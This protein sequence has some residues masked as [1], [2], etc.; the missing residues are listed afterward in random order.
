M[1][2]AY[3]MLSKV[4]TISFTNEGGETYYLD[5][6]SPFNL[7]V[8]LINATINFS[9][10]DIVKTIIPNVVTLR[11]QYMNNKRSS[12]IA[13]INYNIKAKGYLWEAGDNALAQLSFNEK[14]KMFS[15]DKLP[16]LSGFEYYAGGIFET[17]SYKLQASKSISIDRFDW[18]NRHGANWVTSVK[19]QGT[20]NSC[21]A[22]AA[23][24][25]LES[26]INLYYNQHIDEDLSE[27]AFV[28]CYYG[29]YRSDVVTGWPTPPLQQC[30]GINAPTNVLCRFKELGAVDES[31]YPYTNVF[32]L[33]GLDIYNQA[34]PNS[35][36]PNSCTICGN[37]CSDYLQRLWKIDDFR[38]LDAPAYYYPAHTY[39]EILTE[40]NLEENIILNGPVAFTYQPW[41]HSMCFVGFGMVKVGYKIYLP[42]GPIIIQPED[43][44]IGQVYW[45]VKNSGGTGWGENGFVNFFINLTDIAV[46]SI[47][48]APITHPTTTSYQVNYEDADG[49]G[50]YWWGIG[51]KPAGCPGPAE[52]DCD[53]SN[54]FLGPYATDYSCS[55]N[56]N[57]FTYN[58][59]PYN[60][61]SDESWDFEKWM[62]KDVIINAGCTLTINSKVIFEHNAKIIVKQ[63]G[64]LIIDGGTLTSITACSNNLWQGVEV[65]GDKTLSQLPETN[66][67]VI[68]IINGGTI[69]NA[70]AVIRT[71]NTDATHPLDFTGGII[72]A[73]GAI[74]KNNYS[75]IYI[76]PYHNHLPNGA[77]T[78]NISYIQNCNFETNSVLNNPTLNPTSFIRLVDVEGIIIKGNTFTN[79]NPAPTA[80]NEKGDGISVYN[81]SCT[82]AGICTSGTIPCSSYQPNT[83]Q[84]L[85][86]AIQ[87]NNTNSLKTV[88]I[89]NNTFSNNYRGILLRYTNNSVITSNQFDVPDILTGNPQGSYGMY[90]ESCSGYKIEGNEF[91]TTNSG[92]YGVAFKTFTNQV[93][94]TLYHNQFNN[95][96]I[97]VLTANSFPPP[98]LLK[99]TGPSL[100][101]AII[102][103]LQIKCNRFEDITNKNIAVTSGQLG[104]SQGKCISVTSP[105]NNMFSITT[106]EHIFVNPGAGSFGYCHSTDALTTPVV[107]TSGK[108]SLL[109]CSAFPVFIETISCPSTL[110]I[111]IDQPSTMSYISGHNTQINT[112]VSVIDGSNTQ[113]LLNN[114]NSNINSGELRNILL[115]PGPYLSDTVLIAVIMKTNP[116]PSGILKEIIVPNSP[117]TTPVMNAIN[118]INLPAGIMQEIQT[119]QTGTSE[120]AVLEQQIATLQQ[121]KD[122]ATAELMRYYL[123]DTTGIKIDSVILFL[124]SQ[125]DLE[126]QKQLV[127]AYLMQENCTE[128]NAVLDSLPQQSEEEIIFKEFYSIMLELCS[129]GKT[130]F[131]LTPEQEQTMY[132]IVATNTTTATAAK[133]VLTL[134]YGEYY[135]EIIE[136]LYE[137]GEAGIKG[138]LYESFE[139]G[140]S[141]VLDTKIYLFD[142]NN[143]LVTSV[144][145]AITDST[146]FFWFNNYY[147][148]LLDTT[149]LYSI[150]TTGGFKIDNPEL[151]TIPEWFGSSPLT[152]NLSKVNME[153]YDNYDS[154]DSIWS[155]GTKID[156]SG[157]IYVAGRTRRMVSND[158]VILIKYSPQG[159]RLWETIY[160]SGINAYDNANDMTTDANGNCYLSLTSENTNV[161]LL[162]YNSNGQLLWSKSIN[163]TANTRYNAFKVKLTAS[164]NVCM[165]GYLATIPDANSDVF[166]AMFD[167]N[168]NQKWLKTFNFSDYDLLI[169]M[170]IDKNDNIVFTGAVYNSTYYVKNCIT[171]KTNKNGNLLWSRNYVTTVNSN[172]QIIVTDNMGNIYVAGIQGLGSPEMFLVSFN[173]NGS[174]QWISTLP[175][176]SPTDMMISSDNSLYIG[177]VG[178]TDIFVS[179]YNS[180]GNQ[181]WLST[182]NGISNGYDAGSAIAL[183][184][185]DEVYITGWSATSPVPVND[186]LRDMTTLKYNNNGELLWDMTFNTPTHN[187]NSG[188]DIIVSENNN[189]YVTGQSGTKAHIFMS[190]FKYSQCPSTAELR[191]GM[192]PNIDNNESDSDIQVMNFNENAITVY[193]NPYSDNTLIELV[194]NSD[195]DV[196]LEVYTMT[197][198]CVANIY[199]GLAKVGTYKYEFSAKKLGYSAGTYILKGTVNN[200]VSSYWLVE[201]K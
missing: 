120:R 95:L 76:A 114:V 46:A 189:V 98:L 35:P 190:T 4:G 130:V 27:Q 118:I 71:L 1:Y 44:R 31:C 23:T 29:I 154:P 138:N 136:E 127:T 103:G 6:N 37:L 72:K 115:A 97:G 141:P 69:E 15:A 56:C 55:V 91:A 131:D 12:N 169:D 50:Y 111:I 153:W 195:A 5:A 14:K 168:G 112:L 135:P 166:I 194:L 68:E 8:E 196:S 11:N 45:I 139:C 126:S 73:N 9:T 185:N 74:F 43:P 80:L 121:Q 16:N 57:L 140:G 192:A 52:R 105:A 36:W 100:P 193:P 182:Y 78:G 42:S 152:L 123:N 122:S 92:K 61:S 86:Y 125:T 108:V 162:K 183:D 65:Q 99:A 21:W 62:N 51:D 58:S 64:T 84:G 200:E 158:D 164:G 34:C 20:E 113:S 176:Y 117:V 24:A 89:S 110:N 144:S 18:R 172:G 96:D 177:G 88:S 59:T 199:T 180:S 150:N 19:D 137:E 87:V 54:P 81:A 104:S 201:L 143:E 48:K 174:Q 107:Y 124:E 109:P 22:F 129:Q 171:A 53:D 40:T 134:V 77:L 161:V 90:I 7:K 148:S 132:S 157:N 165:A 10:V 38:E 184:Q 163:N 85:N 159:V 106:D 70:I 49:D 147:L 47:I 173:A 94:N 67:G 178:T 156:I 93:S 39:S 142:E 170:N 60:V 75:G 187:I 17:P 175:S 167:K 32:D 133:S 101:T 146:G 186:K 30:A 63:G 102:N 160:D 82:I 145:P 83:F 2:E 33:F 181:L 128:A 26:V 3:P 116:V 66:Q 188:N 151:K 28:S 13:A 191:S 149:A 25:S 79:T 179:K 119:V 155:I 197:G 198:Q 41:S